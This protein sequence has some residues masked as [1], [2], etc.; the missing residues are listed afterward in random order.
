M[1]E[2]SE[3]LSPLVPLKQLLHHV[4]FTPISEIPLV[5]FQRVVSSSGV[6]GVTVVRFGRTQLAASYSALAARRKRVHRL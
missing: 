3:A 6:L 4:A 1:C 5:S 2:T